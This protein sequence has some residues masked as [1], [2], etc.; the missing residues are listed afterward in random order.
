M[1]HSILIEDHIYKADGRLSLLAS[2]YISRQAL[3]E[4]LCGLGPQRGHLYLIILPAGIS[5]IDDNVARAFLPLSKLESIGEEMMR[6]VLL[7]CGLLQYRGGSGHSPLMNTWEY[8][9][10]EQH[11]DEVEVSHFTI[12]KKRGYFIHLHSWNMVSHQQWTPAEIRS[13]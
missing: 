10:A 11:L 2:S 1:G 9:I 4:F 8:F 3:A 13:A 7:H 5:G 12:K 6:A